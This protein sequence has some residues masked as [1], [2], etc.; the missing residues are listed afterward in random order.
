VIHLGKEAIAP[1]LPL[2][3]GELGAG[4]AAPLHD[5]IV[6]ARSG[7]RHRGGPG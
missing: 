5:E 7:H 1:R 2:L 4:N 6:A 3:P